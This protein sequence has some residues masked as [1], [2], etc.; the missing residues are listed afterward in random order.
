[1]GEEDAEDAIAVSLAIPGFRS[2]CCGNVFR[3]DRLR[4]CD[5]GAVPTGRPRGLFG[6]ADRGTP[7]AGEDESDP[8]LNGWK[9]TDVLRGMLDEITS[10]LK[11]DFEPDPARAS[12]PLRTGSS[13]LP[14]ALGILIQGLY[15]E[16]DATSSEVLPVRLA[17]SAEPLPVAIW[18]DN[19]RS[20]A[21]SS[22][23][24]FVRYFTETRRE[25]KAHGNRLKW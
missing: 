5:G 3:E 7:P 24:Q 1:M 6:E 11:D 21:S 18:A 19:N 20:A 17:D 16:S 22:K 14:S 15:L 13:S 25:P 4:E 9:E 8:A 23:L 10:D 2:A 12:E